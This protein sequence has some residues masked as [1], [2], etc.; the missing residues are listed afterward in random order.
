VLAVRATLEQW[1]LQPQT[2]ETQDESTEEK[3]EGG[4]KG[5]RTKYLFSCGLLRY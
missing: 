2:F 5:K 4:G 1:P 3:E